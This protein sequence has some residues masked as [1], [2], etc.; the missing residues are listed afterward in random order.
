MSESTASTESKSSFYAT[1]IAVIGCFSIFL[2]ILLVAYLPNRAPMAGTGLKS[3]AERKALLAE[4]KGKSFTSATTYG[5]V[6][7]EKGVIRIPVERAIELTIKE[8]E[9]K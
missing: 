5:W 6:D 1:F 8:Y 7:K 4:L 2:I 9:K 3:P